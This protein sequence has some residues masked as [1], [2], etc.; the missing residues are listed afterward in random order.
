[1]AE[2]IPKTRKT[3][4]YPQPKTTVKRQRTISHKSKPANMARVMLIGRDRREIPKRFPLIGCR[5][6]SLKTISDLKSSVLWNSPDYLLL[7]SFMAELR[8]PWVPLL[9]LRNLWAHPQD[10][11]RLCR[12]WISEQ[13]GNQSGELSLDSLC[14]SEHT[15]S[16]NGNS[17]ALPAG[18]TLG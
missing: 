11:A 10:S 14:S 1:M 3:M 9:W 15:S 5:F 18:N 12:S 7:S 16:S 17:Q 2:R 8:I 4:E 13:N 6:I